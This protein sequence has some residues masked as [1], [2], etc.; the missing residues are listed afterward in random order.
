MNEQARHLDRA[1]ASDSFFDHVLLTRFNV[2][3][4]GASAPL[5]DRW[6]ASRL[7]RFQDSTLLAVRSQTRQPERWLIFCDDRSP[8]WFRAELQAI[9][10]DPQFE[11]VWV[12]EVF[13]GAVASRE[14]AGRFSGRPYLITTR[15]DNDDLVARNFLEAIQERFTGQDLAFINFLHGA[16]N[17]DGRM[18]LRSDPCN[19]FV[20]LIERRGDHPPLTVFVDDHD[21]LRAYGEVHQVRTHPMWVQVIHGTNL[22]NV[23]RGIRTQ[24]ERVLRYFDVPL[25]MEESGKVALAADRVLSTVRLGLRVVR[26]PHR[27]VWAWRVVHVD[28]HPRRW[29]AYTLRRV[30]GVRSPPKVSP[31]AS[32]TLDARQTEELQGDVHK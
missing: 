9:L 26:R 6:L 30:L 17:D 16:Q 22:A 27:L 4:R 7:Q 3:M 2:R 14:V 13:G 5:S 20:S 12:S 23:A 29:L 18:Y 11:P 15:L 21:R 32:A 25:P 8:D 10:P 31:G 24:P 19:P 28:R 1:A